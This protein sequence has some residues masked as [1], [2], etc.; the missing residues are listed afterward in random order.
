MISTAMK[1]KFPILT[2]CMALLCGF[3]KPAKAYDLVREGRQEQIGY[4]KSFFLQPINDELA[5]RPWYR[6]QKAWLTFYAPEEEHHD[7]VRAIFHDLDDQNLVTWYS[8]KYVPFVDPRF[9]LSSSNYLKAKTVLERIVA[10]IQNQSDVER[11]TLEHVDKKE[12]AERLAAQNV[13]LE[14]YEKNIL[15]FWQY[16]V[17]G[18]T[19]SLLRISKKGNSLQGVLCPI[20]DVVSPSDVESLCGESGQVPIIRNPDRMGYCLGES[21]EC[22]PLFSYTKENKVVLN[23]H[24]DSRVYSFYDLNKIAA[25][26]RVKKADV[27][28]LASG[29]IGQWVYT[30]PN[31]QE[32][33]VRISALNKNNPSTLQVEVCRIDPW[34][35][36]DGPCFPLDADNQIPLV[37][38]F[39]IKMDSSF[40]DIKRNSGVHLNS[41]TEMV[42]F[43]SNQLGSDPTDAD[44]SG[45]GNTYIKM[46]DAALKRRKAL[47]AW[48]D[49]DRKR[50]SALIL[51]DWL[52]PDTGNSSSLIYRFYQ[53]RDRPNRVL[54]VQC[55]HDEYT[56]SNR[57]KCTVPVSSPQITYNSTFHGFCFGQ[58]CELGIRIPDKEI[59]R[60]L[61]FS[62]PELQAYKLDK[63]ITADV[64][65]RIT[66]TTVIK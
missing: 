56:K 15:G 60:F 64:F 61:Y 24:G 32:I 63:D 7:L 26:E 59:D 36:M 54:A 22:D 66:S 44:I 55:D 31:Q 37:A 45:H 1:F 5:P 46:D 58:N 29:L 17:D 3:S 53:D 28:Q 8:L 40:V 38:N 47:Q 10:G 65:F 25:V 23:L 18:A 42:F 43:T 9:T 20:K 27:A 51:G 35:G 33:Y 52:R 6:P 30:N 11:D 19:I 62:R 12:K 14:E 57:T 13:L 50:Q 2:I 39:D 21:K 34:P 48:A 41:Y 49:N 4:I 16:Q